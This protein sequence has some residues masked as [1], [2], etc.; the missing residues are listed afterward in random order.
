[1]INHVQSGVQSPGQKY[2]TLVCARNIKTQLAR[3]ALSFSPTIYKH[4]NTETLICANLHT[5]AA[6]KYLREFNIMA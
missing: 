2:L 3:F 6:K 1:M 4:Y 5:Q